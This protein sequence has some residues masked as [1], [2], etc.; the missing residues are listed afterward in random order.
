MTAPTVFVVDDNPSVRRSMQ[1]LIEAA[2]MAIET[3]ASAREFLAA[4]DGRP[5]CLILDLRLRKESGLDL[6]DE[7]R[8]RH[9]TLPIIIM[10]GYGDVPASVR[11]LKAGAIDFL[12]K[13]VPPKELVAL[14]RKAIE[15]D[16]RARE[17]ASQ[18]SAVTDRIAQLTPREREVM[19]LLAVG[20]T[21][22]EIATALDVSVRTVE[23]H[24]RNVLRKMGVDSATKLARAVV[25]SR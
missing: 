1:S 12:R 11:A 9:A 14:I 8:A 4:Y 13:P 10:T 7:L 22:K 15:A 21:S 17:T 6:Q 3:Y 16:R 5:G 19:E 25:T 20:K 23:G 24:R 2:G 18:R